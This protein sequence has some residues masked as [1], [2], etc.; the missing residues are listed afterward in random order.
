MKR[1]FRVVFGSCGNLA[2]H[3]VDKMTT[4]SMLYIKFDK[5]IS[6]MVEVG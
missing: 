4:L 6:G 2:S 3:Y 1:V 5:T